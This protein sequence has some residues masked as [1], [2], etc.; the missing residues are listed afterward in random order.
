MH[1]PSRVGFSK[2]LGIEKSHSFQREHP[3]FRTDLSDIFRNCT[4]GISTGDVIFEK[5]VFQIET[6]IVQLVMPPILAITFAAT[7][8]H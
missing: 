5:M 4:S 8:L 1:K 7:R 3:W 2:T 6:G